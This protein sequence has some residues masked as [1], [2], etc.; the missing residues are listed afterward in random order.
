[1]TVFMFLST[2]FL[3]NSGEPG[4]QSAGVIC[5]RRDGEFIEHRLQVAQVQDAV[6]FPFRR[7]QTAA[8]TARPHINRQITPK[9]CLAAFHTGRSQFTIHITIRTAAVSS[10]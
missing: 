6:G 8:I 5:N 4:F 3:L 7:E 2:G 10:G 9:S 1:M